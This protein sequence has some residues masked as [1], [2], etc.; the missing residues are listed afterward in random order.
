VA[1]ST[2]AGLTWVRYIRQQVGDRVHF[3][4]FDGW[5]IPVGR[6]ASVEVY[7]SLWNREFPRQ[8]RTHS[9]RVINLNYSSAR[10]LGKLFKIKRKTYRLA[11]KMAGHDRKLSPSSGVMAK[12]S[13][14]SRKKQIRTETAK[15]RI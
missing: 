4:P 2:H 5:E 12:R 11:Q 1:K 14:M 7:P 3:W 15:I 6:S 9:Q 8:G 13:G 10:G